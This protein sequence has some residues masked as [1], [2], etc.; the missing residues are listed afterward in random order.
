M[1]EFR[2]LFVH[3]TCEQL[4]RELL[5][6]LTRIAATQEVGQLYDSIRPHFEVYCELLQQQQVFNEITSEQMTQLQD[7]FYHHIGRL[8]VNE[9]K[10]V[11]HERVSEVVLQQQFDRIR[12]ERKTN[13]ETKGIYY[14]HLNTGTKDFYSGVF[15]R[16]LISTW[17]CLY[18][19][20]QE[21]KARIE[22]L[23]DK[24][25]KPKLRKR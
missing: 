2:D 20:T 12:E 22:A 19:D 10:I 24:K 17:K 6:N 8:I 25:R 18:G 23:L 7:R 15:E 13:H 4:C 16:R 5:N 11:E 21:D 14:I 1:Q 9:E 3:V